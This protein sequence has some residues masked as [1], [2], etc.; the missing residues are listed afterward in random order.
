MLQ[1]FDVPV[2]TGGAAVPHEP[3]HITDAFDYAETYHLKRS[4]CAVGEKQLEA[5]FASMAD[6]VP[7]T[8]R[9][10][11]E[12]QSF[13]VDQRQLKWVLEH[14]FD[15]ALVEVGEIRDMRSPIRIANL[16]NQ[17]PF[18]VFA[19]KAISAGTILYTVRC[20]PAGW[21]SAACQ[22]ERARFDVLLAFLVLSLFVQYAGLVSLDKSIDTQYTYTV[23]P[24][25]VPGRKMPKCSLDAKL[26]GGL[27]QSQG[28]SASDVQGPYADNAESDC[29]GAAVHSSCAVAICLLSRPPRE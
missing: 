9:S 11:N 17:K 3:V 18:G 4:R 2:V 24:H 15:A 22:N 6:Y 29:S 1:R 23:L 27:G 13:E 14:G 8:F 26:C 7:L 5:T 16:P 10:C 25:V 12:K 21:T 20:A 19:K 28:D